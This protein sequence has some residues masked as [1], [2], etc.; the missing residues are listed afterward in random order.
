MTPYIVITVVALGMLGTIP[1][2][3]YWDRRQRERH[4]KPPQAR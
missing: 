4:H 2:V 1:L 3:R